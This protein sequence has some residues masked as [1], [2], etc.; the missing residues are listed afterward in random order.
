MICLWLKNKHKITFCTQISNGQ[1]KEA[2]VKNI[3]GSGTRFIR[4][5]TY[6]NTSFKVACTCVFLPYSL[7]LS[8]PRVSKHKIEKNLK[9]HFARFG[10]QTVPHKSIAQ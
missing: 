5:F 6:I 4:F 9:F 3:I 2:S 7:T 1:T 8:L 10:K